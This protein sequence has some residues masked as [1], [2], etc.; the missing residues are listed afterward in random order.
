MSTLPSFPDKPQTGSSRT[1]YYGTRYQNGIVQSIGGSGNNAVT[2]SITAPTANVTQITSSLLVTIRD[3]INDERVRRGGSAVSVTISNP[4]DHNT[5][6][7]IKNNLGYNASSTL[8]G[9]AYDYGFVNSNSTDGR[10]IT[11][12]SYWYSDKY[13]N[14]YYQTNYGSPMPDPSVSSF[15]GPSAPGVGITDRSAGNRIYASDITNIINALVSAG[16]ACTCNCNYC[17]CNCNY[18]TCNCN[19]NCTCHCNYSDERLKRNIVLEGVE[20]GFNIYSW[21]YI[22][23]PQKRYKGIIAQELIG[24]EYQDALFVDANGYYTV[25]YSKLPVDMVEG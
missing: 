19:Y 9:Q 7:A 4:I 25:D 21:N 17:T 18:C 10:Y 12:Y 24:T 11:G 2:Y 5:I 20:E 13:G 1:P 14:A 8:L 16:Q 23:S 6:N 22:W 3:R 15:Y